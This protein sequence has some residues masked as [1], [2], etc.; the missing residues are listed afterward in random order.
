MGLMFGDDPIQ[1]ENSHRCIQVADN[2]SQ[3]IS[4][5]S[6]AMGVE[7]TD[8]VNTSSRLYGDEES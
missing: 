4:T 5:L 6:R 1:A 3:G 7:E 2:I 8:L